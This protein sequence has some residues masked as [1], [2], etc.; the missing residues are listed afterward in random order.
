[1][2]DYNEKEEKKNNKNNY[3]QNRHPLKE[4]KLTLMHG[5]TISDQGYRNISY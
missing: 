1:M 2:T 3:N 5:K 4:H